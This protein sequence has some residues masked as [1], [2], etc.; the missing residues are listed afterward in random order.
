MHTVKLDWMTPEPEKVIAR[1]ARVSTANPD[2][3]E[4]ARLLSF[5]IKHGHWSVLEQANASFE[6]ITTRAIS[7]Q[8]L[9]H[10]TFTFQ[11]LSMRYCNPWE[12][13]E[14]SSKYALNFELRKQAEKNRQSS[15]D[16]IDPELERQ[17]REDI[18]V[19]DTLAFDL[20]NRMLEAGVARECARNIC[21]LY[22][23]SKLHMNGTIRSWAH[24]V[25]LRGAKETQKE[26]REIAMQIG[27]ILAV[28][29]PVVS[30]ALASAAAK[31][32]EE[33]PLRGWLSILPPP[34]GLD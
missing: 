14:E 28:E 17:F 26:H 34:K 16:E 20:Y 6:I 24:Y 12:I 2:R 13:M 19:I 32:P 25:G 27:T 21:P 3:E 23:P 9:R 11:E 7:P 29:L 4:Y 18:A 33:S 1:H 10:K 30:K 31:D 15:V 8:I 5:C 22:T